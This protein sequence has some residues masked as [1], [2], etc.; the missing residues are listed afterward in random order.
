VDEQS[1]D[2]SGIP[3]AVALAASSDIIIAVLGDGGESVGYDS[4]V[5]CGEG[6]DRPSLDLPGV[7]VRRVVMFAAPLPVSAAPLYLVCSASRASSPSYPPL[8]TR[9]SLSLSC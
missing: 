8:S 7:Q 9:P 6:A 1:L 4:S 5:S 3:D 2:Q